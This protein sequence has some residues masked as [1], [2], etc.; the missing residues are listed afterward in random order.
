MRIEDRFTVS[1]PLEQAWPVLLDVERIAPCMPGAQLQEVVDEEYRGIVKVKMGAITAQYKGAV[2]FDEVDESAHRIRLRAQARE[3]RGQGNASATVTA[4][5]RSAD[6]GGTEVAIDTDLTITGK[7]A[8]FGRGLIGDVSKKLLGQFAQCLEKDLAGSPG[9]A[10]SA[11]TGAAA[12]SGAADVGA[13]P[14]AGV[15]APA[16]PPSAAGSATASAAPPAEPPLAASG[17]PPPDRPPTQPRPITA[18]E[19]E[20]L[21]LLAMAGGS[22]AQ[23]VIPAALVVDLALLAVVPGVG[24]RARLAVAGAGLVAAWVVGQQRR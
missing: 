1:L 21:D 20:P 14:S 22:V 5:M 7:V 8:Q 3:T 13:P 11:G 18:A 10:S 16:E 12:T 4:T 24:R 2:R 9:A 15:V 19:A 17:T 23:R 6:S